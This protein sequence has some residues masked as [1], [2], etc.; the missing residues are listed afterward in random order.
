MAQ[1]LSTIYGQQFV[2]ENRL[3]GGGHIGAEFVARAAP[4]GYTLMIGAIGLHATYGIYSKLPYDPARDIQPVILMAKNPLVII[5]HP[6]FPVRT[7]K[8]F[9][10]LAKARPGDINYGSAGFGSSTHMTGALFE[11]MANVKLTHVPYKGS[12]QALSDLMGGQI[13]AMFEVISPALPNH[14]AAGKL[15]VLAV[16]TT[17]RLPLLKGC[18]HRSGSRRSGFRTRRG[19]PTP[20]RAR[21]PRQ[22][23]RN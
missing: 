10:A 11:M 3:G 5:V 13:Q 2:I 21:S 23:S 17:E 20:R 1:R 8:E 12:S 6:T 19:T 15:R 14:I 18:A 22:S 7:V 4:D 16:T 9:V